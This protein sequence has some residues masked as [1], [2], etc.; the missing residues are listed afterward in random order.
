MSCNKDL[1]NQLLFLN[2]IE[3]PYVIW[4]QLAQQFQEMEVS[5]EKADDTE[6]DD[7]NDGSL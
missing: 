7:A 5:I 4:F 6:A 2:P 1:T 3:A